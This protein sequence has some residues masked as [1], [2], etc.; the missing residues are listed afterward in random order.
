M[1]QFEKK[2]TN[3][4]VNSVDITMSIDLRLIVAIVVTQY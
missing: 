1:T 4:G 2:C 3:I